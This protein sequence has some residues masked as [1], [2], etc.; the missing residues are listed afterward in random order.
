MP[1]GQA[2]LSRPSSLTG[3]LFPPESG[4]RGHQALLLVPCPGKYYACYMLALHRA[5]AKCWETEG[6]QERK[7]Q[8]VDGNVVP[9]PGDKT[10]GD[11]VSRPGGS[12]APG[13]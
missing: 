8:E 7:E 13:R 10:P 4:N 2:K 6:A 12:E 9:F 5:C 3:S 11:P 1:R